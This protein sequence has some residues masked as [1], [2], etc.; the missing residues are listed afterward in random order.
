MCALVTG[1]QT[2]ALPISGRAMVV[3]CSFLPFQGEGRDG[4]GLFWFGGASGA[5]AA[6]G[7]PIPTQPVRPGAARRAFGQPARQCRA[8][9]LPSPPCR[10][11]LFGGSW[12]DLGRTSVVEGKSVSVRVD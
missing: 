4:D 8:G 12:A 1:V 3:I 5:V 10:G 2:C 9:R 6:D 11:G 7:K